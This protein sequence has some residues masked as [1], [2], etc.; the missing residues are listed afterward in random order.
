M[1]QQYLRNLSLVVAD[2]AGKGIELGA[3]RVVFEVRRGDTQTP[4]TCDVRVYN[5]SKDTA[6]RL[7]SPEFTQLQLMVGY[8]GQQLQQ[9]FYGSI[10][11][12]R[13]G[14]ED[15]KNTYVA[16]TAAEG[17]QAYNYAVLSLT[18]AKGATPTDA[19]QALIKRMATAAS[20]TP[21][22]GNGGQVVQPGYMPTLTSNGYQ[23]GRTL[24]G[25]CRNDLREL[26]G[27]NNCKWFIQGSQLDVVPLNGY[28]TEPPVLLTPSTGLIGVPEQTQNGLTMRVLINPAIKI[29]R[30]VKLDYSDINQLRYGTDVDS[31]SLA[32][33]LAQTTTKLNPSGLYYVLRAE[34][35]GDTRGLQWYSDLTC[36]SVDITVPPDTQL[37]SAI[38]PDFPA[39]PRGAVPQY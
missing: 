39:P 5:L 32:L 26:V 9:I 22:G 13:I 33:F 14:R 21:T 10:K 30:V 2:P 27:S 20:S 29:G 4:N 18:L 34:H 19:I 6:S 37:N 38:S 12:V 24:F 35:F 1:T 16:I 8:Q 23:R 15:Q 17:D 36:L 25:M 11:Q 31:A 7:Y 28:V 3:L